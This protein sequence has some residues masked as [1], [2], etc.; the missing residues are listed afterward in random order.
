MT[1]AVARYRTAAQRVDVEALL[2]CLT[3]EAELVSPISG[4]LVFRGHDDLRVVLH[5]IYRTLHDLRW[6]EE[7]GDAA[8]R[9]VAGRAAVGPL[10][11]TD[12]IRFD[13]AEDGRIRSIQPHLRPWLAVTGLGALLA[14]RLSRHPGVLGR[15]WRS[16]PDGAAEWGRCPPCSEP[17]ATDPGRPP[18][19]RRPRWTL[20]V[21][22]HHG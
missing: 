6:A 21:G 12:I 15:A 18:D 5:A 1:D 8:V 17:A 4:R 22:G 20:R 19:G 2:A 7:R 13:L 3:P 10:A 11:V 16:R 14:V 9:F